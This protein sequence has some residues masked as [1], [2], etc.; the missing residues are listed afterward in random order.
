MVILIANGSYFGAFL[1]FGKF[2][3]LSN[4]PLQPQGYF[5]EIIV[6]NKIV[7]PI[8]TILPKYQVSECFRS[9]MGAKT[10][11]GEAKKCKGVL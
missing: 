3:F 9:E 8:K 4:R 11:K 2:S 7:R 10:K 1:L 6:C 5:Q